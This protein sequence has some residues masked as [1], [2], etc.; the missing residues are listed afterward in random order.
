MVKDT[1][2]GHE[3]VNISYT[4]IGEMERHI[5]SI[6]ARCRLIASLWLWGSFAGMAYIL[7]ENLNLHISNELIFLG[8]NTTTLLGICI[9]WLLDLLVY[10]RQLVWIMSEGTYLEGKYS[11]LPKLRKF[12]YALLCHSDSSPRLI[13]YYF[14]QTVVLLIIGSASLAT[15]LY[16]HQ[17]EAIAGYT[18]LYV[19]IVSLL[20]VIV[21]II[22]DDKVPTNPKGQRKSKRS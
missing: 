19:I 7:S 6:Q 18:A 12:R 22:T 9:L 8:I 16:K 17:P 3:K 20:I 11:W 4:E 13:W 5:L 2:Y 15:W 10:H 21:Y 14:L 1:E